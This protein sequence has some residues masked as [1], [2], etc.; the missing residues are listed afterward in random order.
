[1]WFCFS[2]CPLW[3]MLFVFYIRPLRPWTSLF[4]C[5]SCILCLSYLVLKST[6]KIYCSF[7]IWYTVDP[8]WF[9]EK[10][11]FLPLYC[12]ISFVTHMATTLCMSLIL[13]SVVSCICLFVHRSVS[14]LFCFILFCH[15]LCQYNNVLI[16]L[17]LWWVAHLM[18]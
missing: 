4:S 10:T 1:M 14:R 15:I 9:T 8:G 16:T 12:S 3:L 2:F 7:L 17:T 11:I 13:G 5:S 18:M 6:W